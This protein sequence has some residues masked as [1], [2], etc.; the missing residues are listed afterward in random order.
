[1]TLRKTRKSTNK[2]ESD[3]ESAENTAQQ[4]QEPV[5]DEAS[6]ETS[7]AA[8]DKRKKSPCPEIA[9]KAGRASK[10]EQATKTHDREPTKRSA[11]HEQILKFLLSDAAVEICRP[12]DELEDLSKRGKDIKTYAQLLSPFEE[13][14]CAVV[15]SRP[16]SHRLGL[17]TIRTILNPPYE[18]KDAETIKAAGAEKIYQSLDDARTQHR[19]KTTEE[20]E[21]IAEAVKNNDWHNDLEKLR[22][23]TKNTVDEEREVLQSS[24]KGLG[25]T[26]LNIFYRRIQWLWDEA[27]PFVDARTQNS[28]EKLGL[29]EEPEKV[30]DLIGSYWQD[31][32]FND[33]EEF[34]D[35]QRKRR[36]FV[37]LLERS[38]GADLEK[39]IEG[40]LAA[41]AES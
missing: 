10:D 9:Q 2:D 35:E 39:K 21:H 33:S 36:A 32:N 41:A 24:I 7:A 34:D 15:L 30:V 6:D 29:P 26:G 40:V 17:R 18:F 20:I 37:I 16:I 25:K 5:K 3:R 27:Y 8:G 23:Q 11:S 4:T 13:L 12:E 19:G 38:V 22:K 14:V 1:M 31:L 28:L